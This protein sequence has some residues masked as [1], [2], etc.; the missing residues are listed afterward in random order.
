M[1]IRV[2]DRFGDHGGAG[3]AMTNSQGAWRNEL[4]SSNASSTADRVRQ[5]AADVFGIPLAEITAA[6]SPQNVSA[7]DSTLHLNLVLAIEEQFEVQLSPEEIEQM[8]TIGEVTSI[9]G[10]RMQALGK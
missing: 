5:I 10:K 8:H 9:L 2:R 1:A 7:W 4:T 6:S 3:V